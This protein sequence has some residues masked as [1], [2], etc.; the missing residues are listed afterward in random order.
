MYKQHGMYRARSSI[1]S[2]LLFHCSFRGCQNMRARSSR[3]W[4]RKVWSSLMKA[5]TRKNSLLRWRKASNPLPT[6]SRTM[7][8][9]DSSRRLLSPT[10]SL[11]PLVHW[12]QDYMDGG[13]GLKLPCPDYMTVVLLNRSG[14]M[15][16]IMKAQAYAQGKDTE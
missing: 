12:W 8:C 6:G 16:R 5:R 9:Q 14:N 4:P 2:Q 11:N 3:M 1:D 10:G 15:E 7:P 13:C